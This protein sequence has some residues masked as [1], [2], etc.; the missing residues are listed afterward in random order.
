MQTVDQKKEMRRRARDARKRGSRL[1]L[2]PT[3]GAL[4]DG[5]LALVERA[6][7]V[8]DHVT[9]SIFVNPTQF[10]PSEDLQRYPRDLEGDLAKLEALSVDLV[11]AP[12]ADEMYPDGETTRV[13]VAGANRHLCGR[14]R[15][16]HF[17]GV[18]TIVT[19]LFTVCEP[20]V[21]VFGLK[22]AQQFLILRRMVR[23]LG[24]GIEVM[25]VPTV[26]EPDGLAMSSR[27]AYLTDDERVQSA[28]ASQAVFAARDA[29]LSGERSGDEIRRIMRRHIEGAP[30]AE[31]Q[32][33][34]LVD[35]DQ[36]SPVD[37][38]ESGASL[39][40]AVAIFLGTTRLIDNQFVEAP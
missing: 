39:L 24:F 6:R 35:T 20:D 12:T 29:I 22:D 8:A 38:I 31:L 11:F 27:N 36:I 26:R 15:P 4:H 17:E 37:I 25:G 14:F 16:G 9:V 40:A 3:M 21:A 2:V 23:D 10:G 30:L 1:A 18:T 19:K 13:H 7:D 5:H 33:A 34:D 32:Y 28:V